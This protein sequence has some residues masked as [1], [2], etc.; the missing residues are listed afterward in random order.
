MPSLKIP[1]APELG[2][3]TTGA[4]GKAT[5]SFAKAYP[6]KPKLAL[7]P[8]YSQATDVV[9]VQIDSWSQDVAGNYIGAVVAAGDDGGK[10]EANVTVHYAVWS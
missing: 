2:A 4:D 9:T 3:V 6:S 8:E 7:A 10:A 1:P 5:I